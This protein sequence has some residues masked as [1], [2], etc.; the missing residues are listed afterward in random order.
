MPG[1]SHP[2]FTSPQEGE[3][4]IMQLSVSAH[5]TPIINRTFAAHARRPAARFLDNNSNRREVPRLGPQ[6]DR[7]L[8]GSF[9]HKHV[10]PGAAKAP[11]MVGGIHEPPHFLSSF[12]VF[13]WT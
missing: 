13:A 9:G 4:L 1:I 6:F 3:H 2:Q 7:C 11:P 12:A 8:N 10:L 5:Q